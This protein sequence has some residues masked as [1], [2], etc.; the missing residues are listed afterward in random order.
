[1]FYHEG[2]WPTY[3]IQI[4]G[5]GEN[6]KCVLSN[7]PLTNFMRTVNSTLNTAAIFLVFTSIYKTVKTPNSPEATVLQ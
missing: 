6:G 2:D 4:A 3:T 7:Q 1:M 5:T